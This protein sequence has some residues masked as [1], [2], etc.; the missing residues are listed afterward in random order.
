[1]IAPN[2]VGSKRMSISVMPFLFMLYWSYHWI[3][4]IRS[5]WLPSSASVN[6]VFLGLVLAFPLGL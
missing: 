6:G 1:L 3:G 2:E 4:H 5:I